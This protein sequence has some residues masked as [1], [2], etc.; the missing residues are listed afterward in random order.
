MKT[1]YDQRYR[2][3]INYLKEARKRNGL[4][5]AQVAEKLNVPR[6]RITKIESCDRRLDILELSQ[7]LKLYG[8]AMADV[9]AQL[10]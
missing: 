8:V 2:A 4:S 1:I 5:Q 7:I 9:E 10:K 3:A 6:V